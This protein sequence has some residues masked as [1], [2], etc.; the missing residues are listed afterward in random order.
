MFFSGH[1][2]K[3]GKD[4]VIS[5][6]SLEITTQGRSKRDALRMMADA[7]ECHADKKGFRVRTALLEKAQGKQ[8]RVKTAIFV[9]SCND[10]SELVALFLRRQRQ[11]N[12]LTIRQVAHRLGYASPSA[13][14]QYESGK[15][16]PGLEKIS[17]FISAMNPHALFAVDVVT[18]H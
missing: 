2:W 13:Y 8:N 1:L 7:V 15:H 18:N 9:L 6:P 3:E 14:A 5:V 11:V 4:W 12:R 10:P 16:I 17:R